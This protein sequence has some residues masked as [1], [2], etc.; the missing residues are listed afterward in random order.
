[1]SLDST[2]LEASLELEGKNMVM[3]ME[4]RGVRRCGM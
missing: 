3:V 4:G 2:T 1:M